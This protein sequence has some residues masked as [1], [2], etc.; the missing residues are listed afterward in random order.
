MVPAVDAARSQVRPLA[1]LRD[2]VTGPGA[3]S[4]DRSP[5]VARHYLTDRLL[6]ADLGEEA[7]K[8]ILRGTP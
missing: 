5:R 4:F 3:Q 7:A 8:F 1:V 2:G 6:S